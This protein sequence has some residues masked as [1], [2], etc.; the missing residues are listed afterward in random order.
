M[1]S[2]KGS[3]S[4]TTQ[5]PARRLKFLRLGFNT[6]QTTPDIGYRQLYI[7]IFV[8]SCVEAGQIARMG[9]LHP[10]LTKA[11]LPEEKTPPSTLKGKAKSRGGA[12]SSYNSESNET[13]GKKAHKFSITEHDHGGLV[14]WGFSL[15]NINN[16]DGELH[17][18]AEILPVAEFTFVSENKGSPRCMEIVISSYWTNQHMLVPDS[19]GSHPTLRQFIKSFRS[20]GDPK[21]KISYSNL[22]QVVAIKTVPHTHP[23]EYQYDA[24]LQFQTGDE[25]ALPT[26]PSSLVSESVVGA[27]EYQYVVWSMRELQYVTM[28]TPSGPPQR[29]DSTA[30]VSSLATKSLRSIKAKL[31]RTKTTEAQD[32]N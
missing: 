9:A 2:G 19:R 5:Y 6:K 20:D 27:G 10:T 23:T 21:Q 8:D 18:D 15:N 24:H 31:T 11:F 25:V 7:G 3:Q 22:L 32:S 1:S 29:R 13:S 26:E 14:E 17:M 12:T 4:G 16:Q 30:K 28:L